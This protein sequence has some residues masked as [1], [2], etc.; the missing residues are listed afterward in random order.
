MTID[1]GYTIFQIIRERRSWYRWRLVS[2]NDSISDSILYTSENFL[3]RLIE[4][5]RED[6]INNEFRFYPWINDPLR[7]SFQNELYNLYFS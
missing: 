5:I 3:D 7:E 6:I 2:I 1:F 4:Q